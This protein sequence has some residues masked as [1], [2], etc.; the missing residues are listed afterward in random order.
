MRLCPHACKGRNGT[1]LAVKTTAYA[2]VHALCANPSRVVS[3]PVQRAM[4]ASHRYTAEGIAAMSQELGNE[5][6]VG[7][8]LESAQQQQ[9]QQQQ[10]Q[11]ED[12]G[13]STGA[14]IGIIVGSVVGG[15]VVIGAVVY[16]VVASRR[17]G[18]MVVPK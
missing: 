10:Q 16:M 4:V 8:S 11:E 5:L 13:L 2:L 9:Q 6:G 1:G 14:L 3:P 18:G 7:S 15:L 17:A 12:G